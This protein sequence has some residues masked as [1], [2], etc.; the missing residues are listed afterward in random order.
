MAT[1][2]APSIIDLIDDDLNTANPQ[3]SDDSTK[4]FETSNNDAENETSYASENNNPESNNEEDLHNEFEEDIK[5][6]PK[7]RK[8]NTT[9]TQKEKGRRLKNSHY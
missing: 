1:Q 8:G 6:Q 3:T 7:K 2:N 9:G 5:Q 4:L